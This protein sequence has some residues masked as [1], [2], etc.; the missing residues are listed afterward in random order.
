[1][2]AGE[3][4]LAALDQLTGA[5]SRGSGLAELARE[6]ARAERTSEPL[7]VVYVDVDHMKAINDSRGHAAGDDALVAVVEVI[8]GALRSYDLIVRVGVTSSSVSSP[9]LTRQEPRHES[10]PSPLRSRRAQ[11]CRRRPSASRRCSRGSRLPSSSHEPTPTSTCDEV[12]SATST[13]ARNDPSATSARLPAPPKVPLEG[14]CSSIRRRKLAT[15]LA[16]YVPAN[17]KR[18]RSY[19]AP[20]VPSSSHSSAQQIGASAAVFWSPS[21]PCGTPTLRARHVSPAG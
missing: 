17:P 12:R 3:R 15:D 10:P 19:R 6:L 7:T 13:V 16:I 21:A 8:R 2:A 20:R 11:N 18:E 1:M 14:A 5:R 9:D 4:A